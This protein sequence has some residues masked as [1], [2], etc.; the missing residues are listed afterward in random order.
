MKIQPI[1]HNTLAETVAGKLAASLLDGSLSPGSQLPSERDL[2][3]QLGV[4]R[5]TLREALKSLEESRL[6]VARPNVGWFVDAVDE[7]NLTKAQ[8]MANRD[9]TKSRAPPRTNRQ[10]VRCAYRLHPKSRSTYRIC[11]RSAGN[12]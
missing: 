2:M 1:P 9:G 4:S 11:R 10:L 3:N 12:L 5:S 7:S 8:E 6:I